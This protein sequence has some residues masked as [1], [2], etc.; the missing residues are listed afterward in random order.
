MSGRSPS[1]A[2]VSPTPRRKSMPA[3]PMSTLIAVENC[4]R[5]ELAESADD[6]RA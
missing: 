5:I 4:W 6:A 1:T 3:R 2:S